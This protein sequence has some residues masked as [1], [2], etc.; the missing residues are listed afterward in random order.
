[1][2]DTSQ[3]YSEDGRLFKKEFYEVKTP[4]YTYFK[5]RFEGKFYSTKIDNKNLSR[6]SEFFE[7]KIYEGEAKII[8]KSSKPYTQINQSS[9]SYEIQ[10]E[11]LPEKIYLYTYVDEEKVYIDDLIPESPK[12]VNIEFVSQLQ[13]TDE[14]EAFG[15]I[16]ADYYFMKTD[17]Q[18]DIHERW[19]EVLNV[20]DAGTSDS[21]EE[22]EVEPA[23][24]EE[25]VSIEEPKKYSVEKDYTFYD[26]D[27]SK[28]YCFLWMFIFLIISIIFYNIGFL[29]FAFFFFL[30]F[31]YRLFVCVPNLWK[32]LKWAF[33]ALLILLLS[34]F[35]ISLFRIDWRSNKPQGNPFVVK[36][37]DQKS[38]LELRKTI[39]RSD[40]EFV[41]Q[42][43]HWKNYNGRQFRS[44]LSV[45]IQKFKK[46]AS[47]KAGLEAYNYDDV[48][49][50]LNRF[51][52]Q[53]FAEVYAMFDTLRADYNL[54]DMEFIE[55][56]VSFTQEIPYVL[57]LN[58]SCD[59][60]LYQ[61]DFI[62]ELINQNP[63]SGNVAYGINSPLEF[64]VTREG[65]CDTRTLF[66]F[67]LLNN[68]GFKAAVLSS[69]VYKHSLLGVKIPGKGL[70]YHDYLLWETTMPNIPAGMIPIEV[71]NL[72][73][74][75]VSLKN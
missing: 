1:M 63:C 49:Y 65:D 48:L 36:T 35:I 11:Q 70:K 57:L 6:Q 66:I 12:F 51:D 62:K 71:S 28:N 40:N 61:D 37:N 3:Y 42:E 2:D 50:S 43:F 52:D 31:I 25:K 20:S 27:E 32:G 23:L 16:Q 39:R 34:S 30:L 54:S 64:I 8:S 18:I 74:W 53:N 10:E 68:Y 45:P 38:V 24:E 9:N 29:F 72:N 73:Y 4:I 14:K 26:A 21:I 46:S 75:K 19:V 22:P 44:K 69:D 17:Y 41:V 7:L 13:Q 33:Y 5:T 55:A 60:N 47:Y 58:N 15:T 56:M 67:T 59:P